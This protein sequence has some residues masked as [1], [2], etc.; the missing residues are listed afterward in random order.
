MRDA[1]AH[2]SGAEHADDFDFVRWHENSMIA[3]RREIKEV[4]EV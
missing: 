1:I 3:E 2:G 4:E